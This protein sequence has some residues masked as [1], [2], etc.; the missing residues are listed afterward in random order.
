MRST[1]SQG[2]TDATQVLRQ[3]HQQEKT[4]KTTATASSDLTILE[5][6]PERSKVIDG[7]RIS[8][9]PLTPA[10]EAVGPLTPGLGGPLTP[11]GKHPH[12]LKQEAMTPMSVRPG[13]TPGSVR[14]VGAKHAPPS[15]SV[16]PLHM[17]QQ[18]QD[19]HGRIGRGDKVITFSY[20]ASTF[21]P[22][23]AKDDEEVKAIFDLANSKME[24]RQYRDKHGGRR[25]SGVYATAAATRARSNLPPDVV[26]YL[27]RAFTKRGMRDNIVGRKRRNYPKRSNIIKIDANTGKLTVKGQ[28]CLNPA[29]IKK[30]KIDLSVGFQSNVGS[31][32]NMTFSDSLLHEPESPNPDNLVSES[33][34]A[35]IDDIIGNTAI[36]TPQ[37]KTET[38]TTSKDTSQE[39]TCFETANSP[40]KSIQNDSQPP[41]RISAAKRSPSTSGG[42]DQEID[43]QLGENASVRKISTSLFGAKRKRKLANEASKKP[44]ESG[45]D[46]TSS[47]DLESNNVTETE[48][49]APTAFATFKTPAP[50]R[51]QYSR[52]KAQMS[53][54]DV[55][56]V[57]IDTVE[58]IDKIIDANK[59]T[60]APEPKQSALETT[61]TFHS[62]NT[63]I[64][65]ARRH[66]SSGNGMEGS[67]SS[68][69]GGPTLQTACRQLFFDPATLIKD[70]NSSQEVFVRPGRKEKIE[71]LMEKKRKK[72]EKSHAKKMKRL[73][74]RSTSSSSSANHYRGM[75]GSSAGGPQTKTLPKKFTKAQTIGGRKMVLKSTGKVIEVEK[76]SKEE[77]PAT[78]MESNVNTAANMSEQL[79]IK[80]TA[81][82]K[83]STLS[84]AER[85]LMD[86]LLSLTDSIDI[87]PTPAQSPN[88]FCEE[89]TNQQLTDNLLPDRNDMDFEN[90]WSLDDMF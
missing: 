63:R 23:Y 62:I 43:L 70:A 79:F 77:P 17:A 58:M 22:I 59:E 27:D 25:S 31:G 46:D 40:Q 87:I 5:Q 44:K 85:K 64:N 32:I 33:M 13:A 86:D 82:N 8:D 41:S 42:D 34:I 49:A 83:Q 61:K 26:S 10:A 7:G 36:S 72:E 18:M 15:V 47:I 3:H 66:S 73:S 12:V 29:D 37:S 19:S 6:N 78:H 14:M 74:E 80:D 69:S 24:E 38:G 28:P 45:D 54:S 57:S 89:S 75:G 11:G 51:K 84:V 60:A 90:D 76:K 52:K 68:S 39:E 65:T 16:V 1:G 20:E 71:K 35:E 2:V 50:A 55:L 53:T 4:T 88:T 30:E 21:G 9:S 81:V 48:I 56:D 67:N